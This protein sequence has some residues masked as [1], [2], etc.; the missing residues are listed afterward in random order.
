MK[1]VAI[2]VMALATVA[3]GIVALVY[4]W[5]AMFSVM[6]FDAPGSERN[7]VLWSFFLSL[8]VVPVAIVI[9]VVM[10]WVVAATTRAWGWALAV[11]ALPFVGLAWTGISMVLLFGQ[12]TLAG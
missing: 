7:V 5:P 3:W 4:L 9:A 11:M 12:P 8:W 6:L 1:T 10:S 2:V